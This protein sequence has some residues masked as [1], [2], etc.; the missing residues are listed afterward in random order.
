[1]CA[2]I[3]S[4]ILPL[5]H[6]CHFKCVV[7]LFMFSPETP[8]AKTQKFQVWEESAPPGGVLVTPRLHLFRAHFI[9]THFHLHFQIFPGIR[10]FQSSESVLFYAKPCPYKLP[11]M[12]ARNASSTSVHWNVTAHICAIC[13]ENMNY[14]S[15]WRH[16]NAAERLR[17]IKN[18]QVFPGEQIRAL[19]NCI[20]VALKK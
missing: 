5:H 15:W 2:L 19:A 1:M 3:P 14:T 18:V 16:V 6:S 17:P 4:P 11:H 7:N 10:N 20:F 9:W 8:N 12:S 13:K